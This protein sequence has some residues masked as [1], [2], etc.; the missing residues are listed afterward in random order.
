M[1]ACDHL[2]VT[3]SGQGTGGYCVDS[4]ILVVYFVDSRVLVDCEGARSGLEAEGRGDCLT[5]ALSLWGFETYL[6]G[7]EGI[8][9]CCENV[10]SW[11]FVEQRV[12]L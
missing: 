4:K 5:F 7:C 2:G 3:L 12:H 6:V 8:P 9:L 11:R 10:F 1:G